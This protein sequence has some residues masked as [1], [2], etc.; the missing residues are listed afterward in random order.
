M[1]TVIKEGIAKIISEYHVEKYVKQGYEIIASKV[2]TE[3]KAEKPKR[4]KRIGFEI[5]DQ[6]ENELEIIEEN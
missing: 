4:K 6:S 5:S 3:I 2:T 1:I